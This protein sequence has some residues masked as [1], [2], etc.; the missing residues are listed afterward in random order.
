MIWNRIFWGKPKQIF[1]FFSIGI[2]PYPQKNSK[3]KAFAKRG[4]FFPGILCSSCI[5]T[6]SRT[7]FVL[8]GFPNEFCSYWKIKIFLRENGCPMRLRSWLFSNSMDISAMELARFS[9]HLTRKGW[10]ICGKSFLMNFSECWPNKDPRERTY[11]VIR[12]MKA[13]LMI[14]SFRWGT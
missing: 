7:A 11:T 6:P 2:I 14:T 13:P 5:C 4:T 10:C 9:L 12:K 1:N 3:F 8:T